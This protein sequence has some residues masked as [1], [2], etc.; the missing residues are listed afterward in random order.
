MAPDDDPTA[1]TFRAGPLRIR[2]S[3]GGPPPRERLSVDRI[4]DV[5]MRQ[6]KEH[7]YDA[8]SMRSLARELGTGPASLYAHV[9]NKD[10]LDQLVV[11]RITEG[12]TVP[13]PDPDR[14]AEQ[15]KGVLTQMRD[16]YREHPGAAR[17]SLAMVP[18][19]YGAVRAAETLLA[20]LRAGGIDEQAA[21]W[22]CDLS[23]LYVA[24]VAVEESMWMER[25]K[26]AARAGETGE[27]VADSIGALREFFATLPT[28]QFPLVA[29]LAVPL[30]TGD[31]DV[32]FEFG[33]DVLIAGVA[34]YSRRREGRD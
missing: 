27:S 14:W 11:N 7:G 31:G 13:E 24:A 17:A 16:L 22:F 25:G 32:R 28:E 26:A 1:R 34:A 21:A 10:A 29:A 4:V 9:A 20:L 8:V 2:V 18:T 6:M 3:A 19:E 15:L 23:A 12:I 33:L 5:A 30:T